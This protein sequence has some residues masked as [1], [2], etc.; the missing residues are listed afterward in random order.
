MWPVSD[1]FDVIDALIMT[2]TRGYDYGFTGMEELIVVAMLFRFLDP[3]EISVPNAL[4]E[5]F[6]HL[7][8]HRNLSV[9]GSM[10]TSRDINITIIT[11]GVCK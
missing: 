8:R 6:H 9:A 4:V 3:V 7:H 10:M 5:V 1:S 11:Q 2:K